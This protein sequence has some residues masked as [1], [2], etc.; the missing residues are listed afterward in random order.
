VVP[1]MWEVLVSKKKVKDLQLEMEIAYSIRIRTL[2]IL[3][4]HQDLKR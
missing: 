4:L 2:M 1:L 3:S